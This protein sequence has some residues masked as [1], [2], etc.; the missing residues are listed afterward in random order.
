MS[1]PRQGPSGE[2]LSWNEASFHARR[3]TDSRCLSGPRRRPW[4]RAGVGVSNLRLTREGGVTEVNLYSLLKAAVEFRAS[5]L[6][7]C[8]VGTS[9]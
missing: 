8:S 5:E 2:G 7:L 1:V 9:R 6:M 4:R 3:V